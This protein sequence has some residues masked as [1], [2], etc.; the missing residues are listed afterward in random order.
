MA[1]AAYTHFVGARQ[2][3]GRIGIAYPDMDFLPYVG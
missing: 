2:F 1:S 3:A